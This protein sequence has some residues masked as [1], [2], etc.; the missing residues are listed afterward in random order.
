VPPRLTSNGHDRSETDG[1]GG[2]G[3]KASPKNP[4]WAKVGLEQIQRVRRYW[5]VASPK[6]DLWRKVGMGPKI[7]GC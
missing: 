2:A 7:R 4:L 1:V 6:T 5:R 3:R